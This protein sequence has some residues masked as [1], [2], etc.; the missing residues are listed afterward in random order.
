MAERK[1]RDMTVGFIS[2]RYCY[3]RG[4]EFW[5][6][7]GV[8]GVLNGLNDR[9][10]K[11]VVSMSAADHQMDMLTSLARVSGDVVDLPY[12]RNAAAGFFRVSEAVATI[13][14]VESICDAVI[15][16]LPFSPVLALGNQ[17]RPRVYHVCAD[18]AAL[19]RSSRGYKGL[20]RV[21]ALG[22]AE[23]TATVHR[24][25]VH[26]PDT[27]V[28][29]NGAALYE[30][31]DSPPGEVA[32]S[33]ALRQQD[34]H[35]VRRARPASAPLRILFVGYLRP[36]K[37][38][39]QL[40]AAY[41]MILASLPDAELVIV[42]NEPT[43]GT[44]RT[45]VSQMIERYQGG[46]IIRRGYLPYGPDLFQEYADADVL[47]LPSRSE[48]TPRVLIE[49]RA[50]G[51]PVVATRVGGI[52]SSIQ[53][54]VD[55]LMVDVG[56]ARALATAV[57][58]IASDARLRERLIAKGFDRASSTTVEQ[59]TETLLKQ[60][61]ELVNG[62]HRSHGAPGNPHGAPSPETPG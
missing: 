35:S 8:A 3:R 29:T 36:E 55:G 17:Q 42:G 46:R 48:G 61:V 30:T 23:F 50:F 45:E 2:G 27:R 18:V 15:V 52:P 21:A 37:G 4:D 28:V 7:S 33:T 57:L 26:A 5:T 14:K 13:A 59:F 31:L 1:L 11:L 39:D 32:V 41:G 43:T 16:Q 47:V 19:V 40:L 25:L 49:A 20:K 6:D 22:A 12:I 9:C 10:G 60:V 62:D 38:L 44:S 54:G 34:I 51:C 24:K 58:R 56:D 53:D